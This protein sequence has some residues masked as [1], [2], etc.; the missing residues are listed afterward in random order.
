MLALTEEATTAIRGIV[1]A[2]DLPDESGLRITVDHIGEGE[3]AL[4]LN[5]VAEAEAEDQVVAEEGAQ[6]FLD[7]EAADLLDDKVLDALV[8]GDR[9]SFSIVE[10]EEE[11][12]HFSPNGAGPTS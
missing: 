3:A 10:R 11:R 12:P 8:V 6:V 7:E 9:I 2:A 1:D 4:N 5:F